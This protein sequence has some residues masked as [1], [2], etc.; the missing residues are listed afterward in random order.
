MPRRWS[1]CEDCDC[2]QG[3]G[4][5]CNA[6]RGCRTQLPTGTLAALAYNFTHDVVSRVAAA[7]GGAPQ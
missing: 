2:V 4:C 1:G 3:R 7:I 5:K 6:G